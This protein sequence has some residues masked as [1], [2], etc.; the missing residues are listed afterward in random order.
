[1]HV[2]VSLAR[3]GAKPRLYRVAQPFFAFHL[4]QDGSAKRGA[5]QRVAG[6]SPLPAQ[7]WGRGLPSPGQMWQGSRSAARR[8]AHA[9][10]QVARLRAHLCG[11]IAYRTHAH[12]QDSAPAKTDED[13][14]RTLRGA[15]P[16]ATPHVGAGT[17]GVANVPVC[18]RK[19][20]RSAPKATSQLGSW[21]CS[22]QHG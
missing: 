19:V 13:D 8:V 4:A 1:M 7:M 3:H 16:S 20:A 9:A 10:R 6:V 14:V 5:M 21:R 12:R 15:R 11:H 22:E 2:G 18:I 17:R